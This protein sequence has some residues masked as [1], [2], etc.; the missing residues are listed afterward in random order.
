[1]SAS[2]SLPSVSI[3]SLTR[4][5]GRRERVTEMMDQLGVDFNFFEAVDGRALSEAD[6]GLYDAKVAR[7]INRRELTLGEIGC[8]LSHVYLWRDFLESQKSELLVLE[9]DAEIGKALL[10]VLR[11]RKNFQTG[12]E[13]VNFI[14]DT[15]SDVVGEKIADIYRM[16]T[17]RGWSNRTACYLINRKGAS[18]LL[19]H[20]YPIRF[21]AD[22]L[23]GR[24]TETGLYNFGVWPPVAGLSGEPTTIEERGELVRGRP[25]ISAVLRYFTGLISVSR[26]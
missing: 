19:D 23:T 12:W 9:D 15:P 21:A 11:A 10:E 26:R 4:S 8:C 6:F 22:G 3:I 5:V 14:S 2:K 18:R 16:S 13:F 1:M 25:S 7:K 20:A 24:S 17:F